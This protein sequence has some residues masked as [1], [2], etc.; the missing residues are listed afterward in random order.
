MSIAL[1]IA[2]CPPDGAATR[3]ILRYG[4]RAWSFREIDGA[5]TGERICTM[6]Q[7]PGCMSVAGEVVL[8]APRGF[9]RPMIGV[10]Q[11]D[12]P[13]RGLLNKEPCAAERWHN[14][15]GACAWLHSA[16][17]PLRP[18][19]SLTFGADPLLSLQAGR[20]T[21]AMQARGLVCED[22][23]DLALEVMGGTLL[24]IDGEFLSIALP[25]DAGADPVLNPAAF[26]ARLERL[27][28][29][30][31]P[32]LPDLRF[33]A[34]AASSVAATALA[35]ADPGWILL[36][37]D[38]AVARWEAAAAQK[39][40]GISAG[41][42]ICRWRGLGMPDID[43]AVSLARALCAELPLLPEGGVV[44]I[45]LTG[46]RDFVT[47]RVE[48]SKGVTAAQVSGGVATAVCE[49]FF[50]IG[51]LQAM[52]LALTEIQERRLVPVPGGS[53]A[54]GQSA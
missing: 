27:F 36:V 48:Y 6:P 26:M 1:R 44:R 49:H 13:L 14:M 12:Q 50:Q 21:V 41:R 4:G 40:E 25:P 47:F 18:G 3:Q 17:A 2:P 52:S 54:E 32:E 7:A 39:P 15:G 46:D 38:R 19:P 11:P 45:S 35:C 8:L 28:L 42:R 16:G 20:M 5:P 51:V 23:Q 43:G 33:A 29:Q 24:G 10:H 30:L 37:P 31:R 53:E 34:A 9:G 22:L